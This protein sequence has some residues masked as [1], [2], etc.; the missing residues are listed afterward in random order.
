MKYFSASEKQTRSLAESWGKKLRGGEVICLIGDL[1]SGKTVF[2]KGLARGLGIKKIITS[3]TFVL[4]K[5]YRCR[6]GRVNFGLAHLDAYRLRDGKELTAIGVK[7]Y[8]QDQNTVTV[9]EWA[10][11]VKDIWPKN[12]ILVKFKILKNNQREITIK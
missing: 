5:V 6:R 1:G 9:I 3:P 11:R 2:V 12:K 10:D 8:F 7:D 4:M